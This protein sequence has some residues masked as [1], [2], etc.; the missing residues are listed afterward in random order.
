VEED[1]LSLLERWRGGDLAAGNQLFER[2]FDAVFRFFR[3]K[4]RGDVG[5]L[6][7]R[8]FVAC[9]E[10]KDRFRDESSFRT[11]LFGIARHELYRHWRM[12]KHNAELDVGASSL[13][14]LG[15]S[16]SAIVLKRSEER[17]LLAALRGIA[18]DLQL[19]IELYYWE[20]LSG[21]EL[22]SVLGV[23][24]G[25]ARSKLRR[26]LEALRE[27]LNELSASELGST[28][29]NLDGW[30]ESLGRLRSALAADSG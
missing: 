23:P 3:H 9:V 17:V 4:V 22:A 30:A 29:D 16:P 20:G 10:A 27:R 15:P 18:L 14:D 24:E 19:A 5:D 1:D 26:G 7:Q 8:T 6:V 13:L 28:V 25:T 2:H 11:F 21:P 12:N